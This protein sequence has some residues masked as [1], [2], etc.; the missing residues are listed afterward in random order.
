MADLWVIFTICL[1]V[2]YIVFAVMLGIFL[3]V[4]TQI[5]LREWFR[6]WDAAVDAMALNEKEPCDTAPDCFEGWD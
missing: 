5:E 2:S 4:I 3:V 1:A 6:G